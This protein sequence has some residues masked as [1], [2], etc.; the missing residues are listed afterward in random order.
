MFLV[1]YFKDILIIFFHALRYIPSPVVA[2]S[3]RLPS[4][5][6]HYSIRLTDLDAGTNLRVTGK[7]NTK[8]AP[9]GFDF[10][11]FFY[12]RIYVTF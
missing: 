8:T 11:Y 12:A 6:I 9:N 5:I 4:G 1:R 2:T 3:M 7:K 10:A